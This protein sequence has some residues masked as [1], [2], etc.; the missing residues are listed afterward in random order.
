MEASLLMQRTITEK[1]SNILWWKKEKGLITQITQIVRGKEN[2]KS[3]SY[4]TNQEKY[5]ET[6]LKPPPKNRQNKGLKAM[7]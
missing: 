1:W 3:Y 6:C 4:Q 5:G 2:L 7:L